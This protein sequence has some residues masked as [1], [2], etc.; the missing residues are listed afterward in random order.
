MTYDV[1]LQKNKKTSSI[2]IKF[3]SQTPTTSTESGHCKLL[4]EGL[5][6]YILRVSAYHTPKNGDRSYS[7]SHF[8]LL[9]DLSLLLFLQSQG[10]EQLLAPA[11]YSPCLGL[12][13]K[14]EYDTKSL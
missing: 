7:I 14:S 1:V 5:D 6:P 10:F 4:L 2:L 9:L 8:S 3:P 13:S 11:D 12:L